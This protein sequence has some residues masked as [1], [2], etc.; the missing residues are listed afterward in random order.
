MRLSRPARRRPRLDHDAIVRAAIGIADED[1]LDGISMR[2]VAGEVG[3]GAMSLYRYVSNRD[4][5]LDLM[6]DAAFAEVELPSRGAGD[7]RARLAPV[8]RE[9]RRMLTRHPWAGQLV[10][11]RPPLG[12]HYLGWFEYSL[13]V[14]SAAGADLET[15]TRIIGTV[16][17][18]VSG[19]AVYERGDTE[20]RRRH[21]LS[22]VQMRALVEPYL[23]QLVASGRHPHLARFLE[24]G[25]GASDDDRFEFG[26]S[27]VLAGLDAALRQSRRAHGPKAAKPAAK[28]AGSR[29]RGGRRR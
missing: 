27:C 19:V 20:A 24:G 2:R 16:N 26:L 1:G 3:A 12:P 17:A 5:L 25:T 18:Y 29:A 23:A 15:A 22:E 9:V 28:V 7:W 21:K 4:E 11:S 10:A 6:L 13:G 14:V 8:A